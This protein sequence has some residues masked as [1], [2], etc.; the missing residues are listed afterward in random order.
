MVAKT[1]VA[2]LRPNTRGPLLWLA[3]AAG[4][5]GVERSAPAGWAGVGPG[6]C[7]PLRYGFPAVLG[8]ERPA[9]N[10]PSNTT[11]RFC[12]R[13]ARSSNRFAGPRCARQPSSPCAPRLHSRAAARPPRRGSSTTN[14][15]FGEVLPRKR[16]Q[17]VRWCSTT[18]SPHAGGS[19]RWFRRS[20]V[21]G[22][23]PVSAAEERRLRKVAPRSGV[24]QICLSSELGES[25]NARWCSRASYLLAFWSRAP[26]GTRS[27]AEGKRPG[28][29]PATPLRPT[30]KTSNE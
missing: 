1:A 27:E 5:L 13:Q 6:V 2:L 30:L 15:A 3:G 28:R 8:A 11:E 20:G 19:A 10:S 4:L 29:Q 21:A 9:N 25:K 14:A 17:H 12:S 26:Q 16:L 23:R 22:W 24:Q 7:P 18:K